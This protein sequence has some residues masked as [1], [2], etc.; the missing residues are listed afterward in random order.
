MAKQERLINKRSKKI[1]LNVHERSVV[2]EEKTLCVWISPFSAR[3]KQTKA[4]FQW[5][6]VLITWK[7][8]LTQIKAGVSW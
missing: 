6:E 8:T 4:F 7:Y 2:T 3:I 1:D 5:I